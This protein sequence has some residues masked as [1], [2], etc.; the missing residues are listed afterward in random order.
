M[1]RV[2]A[3][4]L[5]VSLKTARRLNSYSV[6]G[7]V[8]LSPRLLSDSVVLFTFPTTFPPNQASENYDHHVK[9]NHLRLL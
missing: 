9:M 4:H 7:R 3:S 8:T 1:W 6:K 2:L 5:E